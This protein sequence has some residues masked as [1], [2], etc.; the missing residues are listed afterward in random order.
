[1]KTCP[2]FSV[3]AGFQPAATHTSRCARDGR[4]PAGPW[5]A[6]GRDTQNTTISW[7]WIAVPEKPAR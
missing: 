2:H 1:L 3:A 7:V 4:K 6:H 5:M